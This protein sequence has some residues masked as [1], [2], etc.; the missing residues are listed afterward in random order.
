MAPENVMDVLS[1][2]HRFGLLQL[3]DECTDFLD[4]CLSPANVCRILVAADFYGQSELESK[5]WEVMWRDGWQILRKEGLSEL[6]E[7]LLERLLAQSELQIEEM[8][9]FLALQR[10]YTLEP[11]SRLDAA[12][13]MAGLIRLPLIPLKDLMRTVKPS[14]LV[15]AD[16]LLEAV[17][18][19]ADPTDWKGPVDMVRARGQNLVWDPETVS[20]GLWVNE[21]AQT[22]ISSVSE[23]AAVR[24]ASQ[25]VSGYHRW[26]VRVNKLGVGQNKWKA[27]LG[28]TPLHSS[29]MTEIWGIV[30]GTGMKT[31]K[32]ISEEGLEPYDDAPACSDGDVITCIF[33]PDLS[34][35]F[36]RNGHEFGVA[37][38]SLQPPLV[39]VLAINAEGAM[40][41][42]ERVS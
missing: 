41:T 34:L 19:H 26:T 13:R 24:G 8:E 7:T 39:P 15:P 37:F 31:A 9:L 29:K 12:R 14:G 32:G 33:S 36:L 3:V 6:N 18:Y 17:S 1:L 25:I 21:D 23:W 38:S 10:W 5:C 40:Y 30:L 11:E 42:M 20:A 16:L 22:V 27:V 4:E 2:A 28:V 35:R